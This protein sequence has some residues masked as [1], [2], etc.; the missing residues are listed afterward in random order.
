MGAIGPES[1]WLFV[2]AAYGVSWIVLVGYA[3]HL[4]RVLR[5]ARKAYDDALKSQSS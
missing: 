4:H 5:R 1:N 3:V 2:G